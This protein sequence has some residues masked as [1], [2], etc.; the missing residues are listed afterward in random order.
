MALADVRAKEGAAVREEIDELR[1]A[2]QQERLLRAESAAARRSE[3]GGGPAVAALEE[4]SARHQGALSAQEARLGAAE[5][6]LARQAAELLPN[7]P[8]LGP[9]STPPPPPP[10]PVPGLGPRTQAP[11]LILQTPEQAAELATVKDAAARQ[12]ESQRAATA[13]QAARTAEEVTPLRLA[14]AL[15]LTLALTLTLPLTTDY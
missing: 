11:P 5:A 14:L 12:T 15:P 9:E 1:H 2:L 3:G 7:K 4:S 10:R 6:I 13:A 8:S